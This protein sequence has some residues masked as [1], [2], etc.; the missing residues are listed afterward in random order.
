MP[1]LNPRSNASVHGHPLHAMLVPV[2]IACFIGTL[3]TDV[4][5]WRTAATL[6]VDMS[7]WLLIVGLIV[8]VIAAAV[9][10]IDF[11]AEPRIRILRAAWI[12]VLCNAAI[13]ALA[14]I[15]VLIHMRDAY[16]SVV[17]AGVILSALVV[18]IL[19]VSGWN[20]WSMVYR[21]RVGVRDGDSP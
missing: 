10:L 17:P 5:Y 1:S 6:W 8:A 19:L 11:L 2:P 20:G 3:I 16:T 12:H 14:I 9:G 15:D 21:H 13:L 7:G 18:L 4:V